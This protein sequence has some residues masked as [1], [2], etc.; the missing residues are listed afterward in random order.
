MSNKLKVII[1]DDEMLARESLRTI[2]TT[3][4]NIEIAGEC[5]NGFEAVKSVQELSPDLVFLD[6]QMPKLDGFDVLELLGDETPAIIFVTAFD[7]YALK[8]F[9]AQ[10]IDYLLKPVKP[11]RLIKAVDRVR[12]GLKEEV[13]GEMDRLVLDHKEQNLPLSRIL[14]RDGANVSIIRTNDIVYIEACDDYV[15]FHTEDKYYMKSERMGNLEKRLDPRT[16]CRIHRS[17]FININYLTKIEPY[18]KESRIAK[19]RNGKT[20]PV[21]RKGYSRLMELL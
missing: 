21:S 7:E 12:R 2:L 1:V 17:F 9:E 19:L 15:K 6:I 14:I 16:F 4:D 13:K 18:S 5:E 11:E 20:L 10:A 8:A 3:M